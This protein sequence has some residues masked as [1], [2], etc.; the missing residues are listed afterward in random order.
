MKFQLQFDMSLHTWD[1]NLLNYVKSA[2]T[3]QGG[4]RWA[5]MAEARWAISL[6]SHYGF[7]EWVIPKMFKFNFKLLVHGKKKVVG[8]TAIFLTVLRDIELEV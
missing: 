2:V 1:R 6:T 3:S 7:N 4:A 8:T 5:G